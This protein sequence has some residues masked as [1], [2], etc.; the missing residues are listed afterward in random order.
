MPQQHTVLQSSRCDHIP[1]VLLEEMA[2]HRYSALCGFPSRT[3]LP[4]SCYFQIWRPRA[5]EREQYY[6][7]TWHGITNE[8]GLSCHCNQTCT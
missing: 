8:A 7:G 1:A 2:G 4:T 6:L 3:T 5:D